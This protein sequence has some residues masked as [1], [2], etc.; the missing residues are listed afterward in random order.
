MKAA[1]NPSGKSAHRLHR[2]L[3]SLATLLDLG[4]RPR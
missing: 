2:A 3:R 1:S 4:G